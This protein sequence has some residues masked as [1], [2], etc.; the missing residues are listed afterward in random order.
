MMMGPQVE[1]NE[2]RE[3]RGRAVLAGKYKVIVT[4]N[5]KKDSIWLEVKDDER[6]T[7]KTEIVKKQDEL[8]LRMTLLN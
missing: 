5:N 7:N 8:I 1:N 4:A 3:Y 6:V 2:D